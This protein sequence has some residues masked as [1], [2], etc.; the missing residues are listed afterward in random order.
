MTQRSFKNTRR[1]DPTLWN[2]TSRLNPSSAKSAVEASASAGSAPQEASPPPASAVTLAQPAMTRRRS[3]ASWDRREPC[4]IDA[5]APVQ[6]QAKQPAP[7]AAAADAA[8][9]IASTRARP[10]PFAAQDT[11]PKPQT[12]PPKQDVT[13]EEAPPS[14][15]AQDAGDMH[16]PEFMPA[17]KLEAGFVH[18]TDAH[19]LTEF[20]TKPLALSAAARDFASATHGIPP[21]AWQAA[22]SKLRHTL[23]TEPGVLLGSTAELHALLVRCNM[24]DPAQQEELML[25]LAKLAAR[26]VQLVTQGPSHGND[27]EMDEALGT[28]RRGRNAW[29]HGV[30]RSLKPYTTESKLADN[31]LSQRDRELVIARCK[32]LYHHAGA[33]AMADA[34]YSV[35]PALW[36][37]AVAQLRR[38]L[39]DAPQQLWGLSDKERVVAATKAAAQAASSAAASSAAPAAGGTFGAWM[40]RGKAPAPPS[41]SAKGGAHVPGSGTVL[42]RSVQSMA[43]ALASM[44]ASGAAPEVAAADM[45]EILNPNSAAGLLVT[46]APFASDM[47]AGSN[48]SAAGGTV[49]PPADAPL[50]WAP[51][52]DQLAWEAFLSRC[53]VLEAAGNA[54]SKGDTDAGAVLQQGCLDMIPLVARTAET[55]FPEEVALARKMRSSADLRSPHEWYPEARKLKR[56]VVFHAGPTNSGKT[57]HALQALK[58][59]QYGV[60]A[61]PLR[62]LALEVYETLNGMGVIANLLTGQ[63]RSSMPFASHLACTVEMAPVEDAL[64]VAVLDEVQ[65]L[66]DPQRGWAWTRAYLGMATSELH[67]CGEAAALTAVQ[68][69]A[70]MCGDTLEV[71]NYERITPLNIEE[72]SLGGDLSQIRPGDAVIAFNRRNI[73]ALREEI[74]RKTPYK[75]AVVYGTLPPETRA[76]QAQRF[77]DPAS[78]ASVLVATDAIGMGLNLNIKRVVFSAVEKYKQ[79]AA[80]LTPLTPSEM[81]Q[82]AGRAGRASSVWKTGSATTL[83]EDDMAH[84]K[85]CMVEA[86]P[87][88]THAGQFPGEEQLLAFSSVMPPETPLDKLLVSFMD[89]SSLQSDFFFMCRH[90]EVVSTAATLH[91]VP[92]L[93]L[94]QRIQLCAAPV[95]LRN[96]EARAAFLHFARSIAAKQPAELPVQLPLAAQQLLD[97]ARAAHGDARSP[98]VVKYAQ[99][100]DFELLEAR[101]GIVDLYIWLAFRFRRLFPDMERATALR[102]DACSVIDLGLAALSTVWQAK[103]EGPSKRQRTGGKRPTGQGRTRGGESQSQYLQNAMG[104]SGGASSKSGGDGD[105]S[106]KTTQRSSRSGGNK[107]NSRPKRTPTRQL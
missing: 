35:S 96:M 80:G 65:L 21:R 59:A 44:K 8:N 73:Y 19:V 67:V 31:S 56:K 66:A 70:D 37:R 34:Q 52:G 74:E 22:V 47:A 89:A 84:L 69:L 82:I 63:E 101:A 60:Y 64:D 98:A 5:P 86:V 45:A 32:P 27:A 58:G 85:R 30:P 18:A 38:R 2:T 81:K 107:T 102:R 75:C 55:M 25:D 94:S 46:P 12:M 53:S 20:G 62:L 41:A 14:S 49:L 71:R 61:G 91:A 3:R 83:H 28:T 1:R 23:V 77:N 57:Y 29:A 93:T 13:R 24:R 15:S 76:K 40:S 43:S 4:E 92:G 68:A 90:E 105:G 99:S 9:S 78:D 26:N 106:H 39:C 50:D 104:G 6:M 11:P 97:V 103:R 10:S 79:S 95:K 42:P 72:H 17:T 16:L 7:V 33:M 54:A 51:G 88:I 36:V 87:N 100:L 48:S